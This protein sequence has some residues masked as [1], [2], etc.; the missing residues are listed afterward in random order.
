MLSNQE[1]LS[2]I[3]STYQEYQ[4][5]AQFDDTFDNF[6]EG[7]CKNAGENVKRQFDRIYPNS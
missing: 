7:R 1:L 3:R 2:Y 6:I 4:D 5:N